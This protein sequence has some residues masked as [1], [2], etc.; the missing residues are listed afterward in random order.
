MLNNK[1]VRKLFFRVTAISFFVT[2][3][4]AAPYIS[5]KAPELMRS[6][7]DNKPSPDSESVSRHAPPRTDSG[8]DLEQLMATRKASGKQ[9]K[10]SFDSLPS[11]FFSLNQPFSLD[12]HK[13]PL[14]Y[15]APQ[16]PEITRNSLALIKQLKE[17]EAK[18][19][20]EQ[21]NIAAGAANTSS[22]RPEAPN[23]G[24]RR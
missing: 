12:F 14:E 6:L 8:F 15:L 9:V 17:A 3:L 2:L 5:R 1:N 13:L 4:L 19:F 23:P 16:A 11:E 10:P 20:K 22:L 7:A 24:E 21:Q 18:A